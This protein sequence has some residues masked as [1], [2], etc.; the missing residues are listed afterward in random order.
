M[1]KLQ[2]AIAIIVATITLMVGLLGISTAAVQQPPTRLHMGLISLDESF[3]KP[4][5]QNEMEAFVPT[6]STGSKCLITLNESTFAV[7]GTTVYC[8]IREI[9]GEN[10][11]FIHVFLPSSSPADVEFILSVYQN[12]A[13]YGLPVPCAHVGGC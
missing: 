2:L 8:G 4:T 1:R 5:A 6:G 12:R 9:N 10:G 13:E 3:I 7:A 11:L